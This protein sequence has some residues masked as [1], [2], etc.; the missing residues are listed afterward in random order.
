[1]L[2]PRRV[3]EV[4]VAVPRHLYDKT[5]AKLAEIGVLHVDTPPKVKGGEVNKAYRTLYVKI[6]EKANKLENYFRVLGLEP[7]TISGLSLEAGG[8]EE[9]YEKIVSLH[10]E[11][12]ETFDRG[13]SRLQEIESKISELQAL[14]AVLEPI[15]HLDAD[16]RSATHTSF[17]GYTVGF[18]NETS[19]E[20]AS[21]Y[22]GKL[23]EKH[24]VIVA[25]EP[26]GDQGILIAVAGHPKKVRVFMQQIRQRFTPI[27]IPEDLPGSPKQAYNEIS[28]LLKELMDSHDR[29]VSM[30]IKKKNELVQYYTYVSALRYVAKLLS[31]TVNTR[32]TA[33]FRGFV[34]TGERKKLVK[35][36]DEATSG[37]YL[38]GKV[39]IHK[40]K[41]KV[42]TK[43]ELPWFL[44]PFHE[45]VRMY[46]EPEP[47]EIVPTVFLAV[48]LP[49]IFGLMFPDA[50]HGLLVILF[51]LLMT[52]KG[53]PWR[54][55][56][57]T[58]GAVSVITGIL[59]GE[60]FGPVVS[61]KIG[62]YDFW[63]HLG[64]ETPP[65]AQPTFAAE[66]NLGNEVAKEIFF[67][68]ASISLWIGAFMLSFGTLLGVVD[69]YIKRDYEALLA[70]KLP[71]FIFFTS[72]T[73]PFLVVPNA[74]EAG[75]IIKEA[76]F[77]LGSA[78]V[79]Q[80]IVFYGAVIGLVWKMLGE[81]IIL[82]F[83]GENPLHG[84]GSSFMEAYEMIA[85]ILGNVPSFL[86]ILGLGLAHAGLMLGFTKLYDI[87]AE[88]G[89]IGLA[90]GIIV[91]IIGNLL[92][93][94]LEAI[95]A[96]AHSLRLHFYEWFSKFYSG[97][98]IS[99]EPLTAEGV[100][101]IIRG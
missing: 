33:F 72:V 2:L 75:G 93:A 97:G 55:I 50:G 44:K 98:G 18:Y 74:A 88:G 8:W 9:A 53:S 42:P 66:E 65:L 22:L 89:I 31:N 27:T 3:E 85:M 100:K 81:P 67:R 16:I 29:I 15:S 70:S 76:I 14:K 45:I 90:M 59:A 58:L 10:S 51:A 23:A 30:L 11:L 52:K 20:S 4:V 68:I 28:R 56:L 63:H 60:F 95:I 5:V 94:G 6:S 21:G 77:T 64:F 36:L 80:A 99:F 47:D 57:T 84:L 7:E 12:E 38:L 17:I 32:T 69:S 26:A 24:G 78:G 96:F 71:A 37:A 73:L 39:K 86:R 62:L 49:I 34:D 83:E 46:G 54:F 101:F 40:A 87:L 82:A 1:M 41:K 91:Y 43:V 25:L 61:A 79:L 92:V 19:V 13:V 48:T 35:A